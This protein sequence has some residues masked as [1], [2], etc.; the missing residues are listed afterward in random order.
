MGWTIR[1]RRQGQTTTRAKRDRRI[2]S[3]GSTLLRRFTIVSAITAVTVG[4]LFGAAAVQVV[5]E[6]ALRRQAVAAAV[7]VSEFVAPRL[8]PQDFLL[9]AGSRRVQFAFALRGLI[10]KAGIV[11]VTVWNRRGQVLYS[12]DRSLVGRTFP[13]SP[14][15][16]RALD[17][18]LQWQLVRT[19]QGIRGGHARMQVFVPVV[20]SGERLPVGVYD[21]LSDLTDLEPVLVRLKWTVWLIMAI[22]IR[23]LYAVV[24]PIVR[25]LSRDLERQQATLDGDPDETMR[26]LAHA[27]DA[28]NMGTASRPARVAKYAEAMAGVMG[29]S[30]AEVIE[31]KVAAFLA[32]VGKTDIYDEILS[33]PGRFTED[34]R[35]IIRHHP[36][37]GYAIL[38]SMP[39]PERIKLAVRHSH[40]CWN[41]SGYPDGLAGEQIPLLARVIAVADAFEALTADRPHR[42]ALSPQDALQEIMRCA[43]TQFDPHAVEALRMTWRRW[44]VKSG[45][46]APALPASVSPGETGRST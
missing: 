39:V 22:A 19:G 33:K 45:P 32:D 8:V 30:P 25:K 15:V 44:G 41:G 35:A 14:L 13:L 12:D 18:R 34:E 17:G 20:V 26:A 27:V 10:G 37:V 7:Y 43:G 16:R 9:S 28:Q 31:T 24:F 5:E 23:V 4:A 38:H 11:R 42:A 46:G 6:Y 3:S 40:E 1:K 29:L 21:V 36:V 2:R